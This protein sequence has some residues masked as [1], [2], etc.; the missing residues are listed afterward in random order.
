MYQLLILLSKLYN[1]KTNKMVC[2]PSE[3]SNQPGHPPS[4]IRVLAVCMKKAWVLSYPLSAQRRLWSDWADTKAD[5]SLHWAHM[6]FCWFC[7]EVAHFS[8]ACTLLI[9]KGL[10][11]W[12]VPCEKVLI[13][14]KRN[15]QQR[16][17]WAHSSVQSSQ[18]IWSFFYS[19]WATAQQNQQND[20]GAQRGSDQPGQLPSLIRVFTV[21]FMGN[22]GP[23]AS[24]CRQQRLWSEWAVAQADLSFHWLHSHFVG[25]VVRRL[26]WN[27][28]ILRQ[29]AISATLLSLLVHL[30][31]TMLS[32]LF[33]CNVSFKIF[34][35][36]WKNL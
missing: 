17:W 21:C 25:F 30:K 19:I 34:L 12:V 5:L 22:Q 7:H 15:K 28:E 9:E 24:S 35:N 29:I 23:N 14:K 13:A 4:L 20:L 27:R 3:D 26:I 32:F 8:L 33:S 1:D 31:D 16:L 10:R 6:P 18:S 36:F 11:K 2:A